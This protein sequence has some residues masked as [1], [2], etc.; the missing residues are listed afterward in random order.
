MRRSVYALLL[1]FVLL[2][3]GCGYDNHNF[4]APANSSTMY[5]YITDCQLAFSGSRVNDVIT[6]KGEE[7]VRRITD[8]PLYAINCFSRIQAIELGM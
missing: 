3:S 2:L 1:V 6:V 8:H 4:K 7:V 5:N